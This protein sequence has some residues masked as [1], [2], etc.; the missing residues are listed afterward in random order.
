MV[1]ESARRVGCGLHFGC[2]YQRIR[3]N[4][5]GYDHRH[6]KCSR[7][8]LSVRLQRCQSPTL[9]ILTPE[10]VPACSNELSEHASQSLHLN[11]TELRL[12]ARAQ[13][14]GPTYMLLER[15]DQQILTNHGKGLDSALLEN[16]EAIF[17]TDGL[18]S[19]SPLSRVQSAG[20]LNGVPT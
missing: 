12:S 1:A 10:N 4:Y 6:L 18:Q 17:K 13:T 11:K 5:T 7:T 16:C 2:R 9:Q 3:Q 14:S 15:K 19:S 20:P 8:G